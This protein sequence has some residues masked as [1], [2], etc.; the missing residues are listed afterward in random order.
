M[1]AENFEFINAQIATQNSIIVATRVFRRFEG[2]ILY[3]HNALHFVAVVP[4]SDEKLATIA[5]IMGR[6]VRMLVS[7]NIE[8]AAVRA[9]KFNCSANF[10]QMQSNFSRIDNKPYNISNPM[11][12][13][14]CNV[15]KSKT[16][17]L[18]FVKYY[19]VP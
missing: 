5:Y 8:V 6:I 10:A 17:F 7:N 4:V 2:A 3:T 9:D 14:T 15:F 19:G 16:N 18:G 12:S 11:S 13:I 1:N